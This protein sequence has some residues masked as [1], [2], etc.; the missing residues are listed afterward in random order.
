VSAAAE[1]PES[2][3]PTP[4][5]PCFFCDF[6]SEQGAFNAEAHESGVMEPQKQFAPA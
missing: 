3:R 4:L 1:I 2:D 5:Q 6:A